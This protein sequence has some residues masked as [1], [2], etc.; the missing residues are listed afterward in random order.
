MPQP[1]PAEALE[2]AINHVLEQGFTFYQHKQIIAVLTN[3]FFS[4]LHCSWKDLDP[5]AAE[6]CLEGLRRD[7]NHHFDRV[8]SSLKGQ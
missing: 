7:F 5:A 6:L 2:A 4:V 8:I 1:T 3:A